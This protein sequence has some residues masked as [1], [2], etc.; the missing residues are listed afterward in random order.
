MPKPAIHAAAAR[1]GII[2]ASARN[3]GKSVDV[4]RPIDSTPPANNGGTRLSRTNT[5]QAAPSRRN[6]G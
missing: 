5:P 4:S 6:T 1:G 2:T 3:N